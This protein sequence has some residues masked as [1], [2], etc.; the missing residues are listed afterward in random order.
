MAAPPPPYPPQNPYPQMPPP[1]QPQR[2][3]SRVWLWVL[4][5][6]GALF[7]IFVLLVGAGAYFIK[8]KMHQ[9]GVTTEMMRRNPALAGAK[10]AAAMN[11]NIEILSV[12]EDR[13]TL[14]YRDKKTGKVSVVTFQNAKNGHW[15]ATEE[16][17]KP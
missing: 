8:Q 6:L 9:A 15:T 5:I 17:K 4:G 13:Q 7:L 11:P 10:I 2:R 3:K 12:D 16:E 1:Y 14:T